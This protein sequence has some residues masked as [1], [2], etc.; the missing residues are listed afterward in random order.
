MAVTLNANTTS[1]AFGSAITQLDLTSLTIASGSNRA[2]LATLLLD[3]ANDT[4]T[5]NWDNGGTP[6]AMTSIGFIAAG[7]GRLWFFGLIAPTTGNLTLRASWSTSQGAMLHAIAFEGVDQ[8][9]VAVAFPHF[10]SDTQSSATPAIVITSATGNFTVGV[11]CSSNDPTSPTQTENF[12]NDQIGLSS[13]GSRAT[14]AATVTHQWSLTST[15]W[16]TIGVDIL[17]SGGGG[18]PTVAQEMPAV[19]QAMA[20]GTVIGRVDA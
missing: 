18:G 7:S 14:G 10:T 3:S 15:T 19:M 17:A 8:T 16:Q 13:D 5:L 4:P 2:L 20:S 9:S 12:F 1:E 11:A 6:Q